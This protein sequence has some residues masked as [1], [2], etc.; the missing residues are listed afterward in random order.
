MVVWQT[1]RDMCKLLIALIV[2]SRIPM[3]QEPVT[4][5]SIKVD[6]SLVNVAFS[7]RNSRGALVDNLTGN[8]TVI[9]GWSFICLHSVTL[10]S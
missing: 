3:A 9:L 7:A 2:V 5:K 10:V 8:F 4:E 1:G 6:V